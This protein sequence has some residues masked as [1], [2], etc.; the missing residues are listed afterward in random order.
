MNGFITESVSKIA[1][2]LGSAL[3]LLA[4]VVL[5]SLAFIPLKTHLGLYGVLGLLAILLLLSLFYLYRSFN[6][7]FEAR[8]KAW[9]GMAAGALLWQVTRYLPEVPGWGWVSKAGILYWAA[10]ALLTLIL[11]KN[12]LNVGGRF[13]LLT[14]LLNWI[15]GI[16][17]AT[18]DRAGLWP[19]F[20]AQAYASVHY[21]GIL[22]IMASI[23]W[24]VMRSHNSLERKY[25]GLALY[26]SVL[27]TFLF[28]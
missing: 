28:F 6:D 11:W 22:G 13:T 27:F 19:Q 15:G 12:V 4:F 16:Y 5:T 7:N 8:Q 10:A 20:M 1:D 18:L 14:F 3:K 2:G 24:I 21:L 23:W 25:G 17:L 26:F 9:C